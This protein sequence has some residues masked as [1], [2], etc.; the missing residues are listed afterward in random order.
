MNLF[1]TPLFLDLKKA[2]FLRRLNRFV[3][4]CDLDGEPVTAHLPNPGRLWELLLPGRIVSLT[5]NAAHPLRTTPYTAVSVLRSGVPVLLHTQM[6][7]TVVRFL[8]EE[9][10]L[11][12]LEDARI[13][14]QEAS[15]GRSRFDFLLQKGK[16]RMILEVKSC[17]LFGREL[18]MFPDAVTERGRKHLLELCE[19]SRQG[20]TCGV[21]FVVST[22]GAPFFLPDYHT[23]FAFS[24]A[25]LDARNALTIQAAGLQ[26]HDDL[27]LAEDIR[28]IPIP[29]TLLEKEGHDRGC[30][31]L[32]LHLPED[33]TVTIG[34]I[35]PL[36]FRKGYYLYAGSAKKH[37]TKRLERHCR[38]RKTFF[39]HIDYLRDA[40]ASCL[41]LPIRTSDDLEH[42]LAGAVGR[43]ALWSVPRFGASDCRC[44][45]HLF[46]M[47]GNPVHDPAFLQLLQYFRMDRL[48]PDA[49]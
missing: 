14:R 46:G 28:D 15:F 6:T 47:T 19:L 13:I 34:S 22:L 45:T 5:P 36:F 33:R 9:G 49:G 31:L 3:I 39:W 25:L 48:A 30:Y 23:D 10:R 32:I 17:T 12:G 8:L 20:F 16:A 4:E 1:T 24:R 38:K 11:P 2:L 7:N 29:W 40:A 26:W 43:I 42:E 35:G 27:T 37:L 21:L 18:A 44:G 41:A